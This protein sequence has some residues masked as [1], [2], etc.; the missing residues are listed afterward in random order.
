MD[1]N[2]Q[3][4]TPGRIWKHR[5]PAEL[6]LQGQVYVVG[7]HT[8]KHI[9]C[10][11]VHWVDSAPHAQ[12]LTPRNY[13][14]VLLSFP[15]S[16]FSWVAIIVRESSTSGLPTRYAS[17]TVKRGRKPKC[18]CYRKPVNEFF[19]L[20]NGISCAICGFEIG[21]VENSARFV[22]ILPYIFLKDIRINFSVSLYIFW[23]RKDI[24]ICKKKFH[25]LIRGTL[26]AL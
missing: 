1:I 23:A 26:F 18:N 4:T 12:S 19:T 10:T 5:F 24:K 17:E 14:C 3:L 15:K 11:A 6:S 9:V 20:P 21:I 25:F 7:R 22:Y 2:C 16:F 13:A 8:A